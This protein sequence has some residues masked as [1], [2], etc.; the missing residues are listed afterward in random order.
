MNENDFLYARQETM[1]EDFGKNLW[2][3]L[4][5][6]DKKP[7][8]KKAIWT[9]AVASLLTAIMGL[10]LVLSRVPAIA[11]LM[12][13]PSVPPPSFT[14][15]GLITSENIDQLQPFARLGNG[16][17]NQIYMMPDGE[18]LLV[19][20][21][22]GLFL[23]DAQD[24]NVEPEPITSEAISYVDVDSQGNIFGVTSLLAGT[25]NPEQTVV[26]WDAITNERHNLLQLPEDIDYIDDI[27]VKPDRSQMM[28]QMCAEKKFSNDF[29]WICAKQEFAWFDTAN[30]ELLA[31]DKPVIDGQFLGQ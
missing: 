9:V 17:I 23:H 7:Q 10:V 14:Q 29:G 6:Q 19:A 28:V 4:Q 11:T 15:H 8:P 16:I 2:Q 24:L 30:G 21:S 3:Q 25:D 27:S 13:A 20:A 22:T 5:E 1:P 31:L 26:R 18:H 12:V